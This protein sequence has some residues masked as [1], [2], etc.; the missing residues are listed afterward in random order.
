MKGKHSW[1][2]CVSYNLFEFIKCNKGYQTWW[3][4]IVKTERHCLSRNCMLSLALTMLINVEV[5]KKVMEVTAWI[6][7]L[8]FIKLNVSCFD[9]M[10]E[11]I[12]LGHI[13]S[14]TLL[15][16]YYCDFYSCRLFLFLQIIFVVTEML[17]TL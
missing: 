3:E 16:K 17:F 5:S 6:Q 15:I 7:I 4:T 2:Y 11:I 12:S 10:F 14:E 13:S 8:N 1:Q 9:C